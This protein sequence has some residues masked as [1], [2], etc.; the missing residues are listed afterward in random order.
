MKFDVILFDLGGTLMYFDGRWPEI[1][2]EA[3][4]ALVRSLEA[5]GFHI[6]ESFLPAFRRSLNEYYVQR[7]SEFIEYT[8]AYVLRDLLKD[9]GY[10]EISEEVL[11]P[12]L[13][14]L[15]AVTQRYWKPEPDARSTLEQLR[16]CGYGLGLIS[17]AGDDPDVQRL[18]D[19]AGLRPFFDVILS[20]A[21]YGLRKPNPKIF[22][23]A[24]KRWE[25]GRVQ[26]AMVGDTLGADILGAQN[27]GLFGIWL[28]RWADTPA[29]REHAQTIIP[30]ATIK[31]LSELPGLLDELAGS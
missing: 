30:D 8:T 3:D 13:D 6:D 21:A 23:E 1:F 4:A 27:A 9:Y 12:A 2:G 14:E 31:T 5:S 24:L 7:E 11:R 18:I 15:Y 28:T 29:N 10:S 19:K 25:H 22:H 26:A 17:N 20:S 16:E